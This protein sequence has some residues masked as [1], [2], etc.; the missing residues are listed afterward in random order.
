VWMELIKALFAGTILGQGFQAQMLVG[1]MPHPTDW[2]KVLHSAHL[3]Y[4]I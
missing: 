2:S 3:L 4:K 1:K